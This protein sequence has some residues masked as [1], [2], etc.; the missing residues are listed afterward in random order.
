[1]GRKKREDRAAAESP[2]DTL[3]R[4]LRDT[5]RDTA[6]LAGDF[7]AAGLLLVAAA[8]LDDYQRGRDNLR[9][10]L[11]ECR[12]TME[13]MRREDRAARPIPRRRRAPAAAA[14]PSRNRPPC[15][16]AAPAP[17]PAS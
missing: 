5:A 15:R 2:H 11:E 7:D 1:M 12:G 8:Q 13:K 9:T 6:Q 3:T 16:A 10:Q 17:E 4:R 14:R